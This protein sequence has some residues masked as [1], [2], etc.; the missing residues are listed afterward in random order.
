M[1]RHLFGVR[2]RS[3]VDS[4]C[5][6][7]VVEQHGRRNIGGEIGFRRS[8]A[9]SIGD[10]LL[11]HGTTRSIQNQIVAALYLGER[12]RASNLL[13]DFV[14][15]NSSLTPHDFVDILK[16]CARSP[17]PL[18][19]METWSIL[20]EK[21]IAMNNFLCLLMTQALCE[22]GYLTEAFNLINFIGEKHDTFPSLAVYNCFLGACSKMHDIILANK[23]LD[24]ME[25]TVAGKNEDTYLHLLKFAVGQQNLS[26]VHQIWKNYIT[27]YSPHIFSLQKF[28]WSLTSLRDLGSAFKLLQYMVALTIR[29][30]TSIAGD[31]SRLDIPIPCNVEVGLQ[32]FDLKGI[33]VQSTLLKPYTK[34]DSTQLSA[35]FNIRNEEVKNLGRVRLVTEVLKSSFTSVIYECAQSQQPALAKLLMMQIQ[36]LGLQPSSRIYDGFVR[37]VMSNRDICLGKRIKEGLEVLKVM[38]LRNLKPCNSTLATLSDACCEVSKLDVAEALLD[39]ISNQSP[40][41]YNVFLRKCSTLD[42][43]ERAIHMWA[44]MKKLKIEPVVDTYALLFLLFG[45]VNAPYERGDELSW[46]DSAKRIDALE[47]D[48][49]RNGVQHNHVSIKCLLRVLAL[50]G[51]IEELKLYLQKIEDILLRNN[52]YVGTAI[53]NTV[54]D[55][56]VKSNEIQ[57]A[58]AIFKKM[59]SSGVRLDVAT[60]NIMIN[61]CCRI[62]CYKSASG[63][64]SLMLRDG[65]YPTKIT[66]TVLMKLLLVEEKFDEAL[67]LFAQGLSEGIEPDAV[68]YNT[69]LKKACK[70]G[71]IDVIEFIAEEMHQRKVKPDELT[72]RY[73][74]IGY[75]RRHFPKTA[76][77]ALNV[78]C[79]RMICEEYGDFPRARE[80]F[81][82][83]ILSEDEETESRIVKL[84]GGPK[85][86]IITALLCL[87]WC[88][89]DGFSIS[90]SPDETQWATRLS[91]N[92]DKVKDM[93]W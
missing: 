68:L 44:K 4:C 38:K 62:R 72:C 78:L 74:Y 64:V 73:V 49:A 5:K 90:W 6:S 92:H 60:Y 9:T 48:M 20:E 40:R 14:Q 70:R 12:G 7:K 35:T 75:V 17:D 3:I 36:N 37:A 89:M 61:C 25:R 45:N 77:E 56:L 2:W 93:F 51:M 43:P 55:G 88:A 59:K 69:F 33:Y 32:S 39:Q 30:N 50:E 15:A 21:Q 11:G 24:L 58:I 80:Q 1:Y 10:G 84:F 28:I 91:T 29:G 66:Y 79:V 57:L 86:D 65:I 87:R 71:R 81:E 76:M 31:S 19:A 67:Y 18:F 41:P 83:L 23:C 52:F 8:I 22:G 27:C 85:E 82:D 46:L 47:M 13:L 42:Q 16:Y 34:S 63:L 54:L 26:A 53:Y